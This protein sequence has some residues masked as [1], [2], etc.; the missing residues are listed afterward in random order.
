MCTPTFIHRRK[1]EEH[2]SVPLFINGCIL[3]RECAE[4]DELLGCR[5]RH[6]GEEP[7]TKPGPKLVFV[8]RGKE[9]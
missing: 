7:D 5:V 9:I 6:G 2:D 1:V 3:P 4:E 8:P